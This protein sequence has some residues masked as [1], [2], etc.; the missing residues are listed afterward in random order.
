MEL[1]S[2]KSIC[3]Y[4]RSEKRVRLPFKPLILSTMTMSSEKSSFKKGR[5]QF[6]LESAYSFAFGG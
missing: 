3:S 4:P 6:K 2:S 1:G 5:L